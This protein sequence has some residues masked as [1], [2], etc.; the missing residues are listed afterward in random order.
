MESSMRLADRAAE[1]VAGFVRGIKSETR[2]L[3]SKDFRHFDTVPVIRETLLLLHHAVRKQNCT[4]TF[5][6]DQGLPLL[7][8]APGRLAQVVTNLVTNAVDASGEKGGG[9]V[10][11]R[12]KPWENGLE[13]RVTDDGTGISPENLKRIFDP[14]FT[15]KPFGVGTGLGLTIVHDIVCGDFNGSIDVES[16]MG[17]GTTFVLRLA[18]PAAR[19]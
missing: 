3:S 9:T 18:N 6:A 16:R 2:D 10:L 19:P 1:R 7:Y 13:L 8:G 12:L 11:L 5:D 17:I 14:M 15:S 4:V